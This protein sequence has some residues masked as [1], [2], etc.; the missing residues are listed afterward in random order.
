MLK[1]PL[2]SYKISRT[3]NVINYVMRDIKYDPCMVIRVRSFPVYFESFSRNEMPQ[4][5]IAIVVFDEIHFLLGVHLR[6][7]V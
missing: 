7:K 4:E 6:S 5:S 3:W 1:V 2:S